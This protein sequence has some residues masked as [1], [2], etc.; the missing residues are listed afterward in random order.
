[1]NQ[2][3]ETKYHNYKKWLRERHLQDGTWVLNWDLQQNQF[4]EFGKGDALFFTG[5][6]LTALAIERNEAEYVALLQAVNRH[7]FTPGM[8]PRYP[9]KFSTSKDQYYPLILALVY[10]TLLF[11]GQALARETLREIIDAVRANNHRLKNP[12][13]TETRHGDMNGFKPVFNLIEGRASFNYY[14]SL[15][16]LPGLSAAVNAAEK[17]YYNNFMIGCHY[18]LYHLFVKNNFERK[19]LQWSSRRFAGV[20]KNN[21]FFLMVRDLICRNREHQAEVEK[22]LAIFTDAH[23]PN[24]K[25]D[26]AHSDVL[27]QRDPRNWP[28][29]KAEL[30]HEYAG[31]DYMLLHQFYAKFYLGG[32]KL[33]YRGPRGRGII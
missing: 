25:D 23:L 8:Y 14:L 19:A 29:A 31:I 7:K 26:I 30:V 9:G 28:N 13:G 2:A 12:D 17:S 32:E 22:I 20:N 18:L 5:I 4:A 33:S 24:D 21:P 27:W 3:F 15:G 11:P 6:L 1:M 10:G 16:V